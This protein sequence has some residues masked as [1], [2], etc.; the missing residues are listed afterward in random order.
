MDALPFLT[1]PE[2]VIC[3]LVVDG[4]PFIMRFNHCS[5]EPVTKSPSSSSSSPGGPPGAPT[6]AAPGKLAYALGQLG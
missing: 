2:G 1:G 6:P 5:T 3:G 4:L